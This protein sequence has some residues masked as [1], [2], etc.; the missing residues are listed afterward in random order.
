[1]TWVYQGVR[2][3]L[4]ILLRLAMVDQ[5]RDR[6]RNPIPPSPELMK[7]ADAFRGATQHKNASDESIV[8][9]YSGRNC[10]KNTAIRVRKNTRICLLDTGDGY[11]LCRVWVSKSAV[12]QRLHRSAS[13]TIGL[14]GTYASNLKSL[15][16]A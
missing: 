1:M 15:A 5:S 6:L 13:G 4:P 16:M 7:L 12:W 8:K 3:K 2:N 14:S 9:T 11:S 10:Q